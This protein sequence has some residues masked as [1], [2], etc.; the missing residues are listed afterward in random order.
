MEEIIKVNKSESK[1]FSIFSDIVKKSKLSAEQADVLP[2][3]AFGMSPED[4]SKSTGVP[5]AL[6]TKWLNSDTVFLSAL[7]Q[8]SVHIDMYHESKLNQAGTMAWTKVFDL[9]SEDTEK[10]YEQK[11]K[12][13]LQKLQADVAKFIIG[14]LKIHATK[15]E[16]EHVVDISPTLNVTDTSANLIAKRLHQLQTTSDFEHQVVDGNFRP[17]DVY[18]DI[19]V[20]KRHE[21]IKSGY[22]PL[23]DGME[24][25]VVEYG[26]NGTVRCHICGEYFNDLL[27]HI[28]DIHNVDGYG[29]RQMFALEQQILTNIREA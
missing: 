22:A 11:E 6:I 5:A 3:I 12:R 19:G 27:G 2:L 25:G 23:I 29:Y 16:V 10:V 7:S 17:V 21:E 9:L 20:E 1:D 8:Y 24:Y 18:T 14:E 4:C 13:L 15:S 28:S 26:D